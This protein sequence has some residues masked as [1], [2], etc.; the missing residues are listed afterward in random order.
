[1]RGRKIGFGFE[2]TFGSGCG[3]GGGDDDFDNYDDVR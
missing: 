1:M 2:C 3:V